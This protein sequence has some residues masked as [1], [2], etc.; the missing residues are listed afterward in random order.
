MSYTPLKVR[1]GTAVEPWHTLS[2]WYHANTPFPLRRDPTPSPHRWQ[3]HWTSLGQLAPSTAP[4]YGIAVGMLA[5]AL[6]GGAA[7][8]RHQRRSLRNPRR[9]RR[10]SH[11]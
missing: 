7:A 2:L 9:R 11:R 5:L 10:R 6:L 8:E 4:L 1:Y 3:P